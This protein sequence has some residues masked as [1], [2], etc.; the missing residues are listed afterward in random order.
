MCVEALVG[1]SDLRAV[2]AR[3]W[4]VLLLE[5]ATYCLRCSEVRVTGR[6]GIKTSE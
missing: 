3:C 4:L 6:G 2:C 1:S 5:S